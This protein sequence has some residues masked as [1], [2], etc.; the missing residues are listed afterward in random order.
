ME[1]KRQAD[2]QSV[3]LRFQDQPDKVTTPASPARD[4]ASLLTLH[5]QQ[6]PSLGP[7]ITPQKVITTLEIVKKAC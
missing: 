3:N 7:L 6:T 2:C 5:L 1:S 4:P